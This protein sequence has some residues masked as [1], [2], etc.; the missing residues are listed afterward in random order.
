LHINGHG[1]HTADVTT[2]SD[3]QAMVCAAMTDCT[4]VYCSGPHYGECKILERDSKTLKSEPAFKFVDEEINHLAVA[5]MGDNTDNVLLCYSDRHSSYVKCT[6]IT[7]SG[8]TVSAGNSNTIDMEKMMK[9]DMTAVTSDYAMLCGR[10]EGRQWEAGYWTRTC[11]GVE[12]DAS[13]QLSKSSQSEDITEDS[14]KADYKYTT[15]SSMGGSNPVFVCTNM[16]MYTEYCTA[17][18]APAA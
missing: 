15:V 13:G 1:G 9:W 8:T 12:M 3:T 7:W 10:P 6:V 17:L 14:K 2:I 11:Q 18:G 4:K 5:R 16:D